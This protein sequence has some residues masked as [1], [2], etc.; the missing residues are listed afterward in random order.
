MNSIIEWRRIHFV[1]FESKMSVCITIHN[2]HQQFR[3]DVQMD[4]LAIALD[5]YKMII[6]MQL[7]IYLISK[8]YEIFELTF[9]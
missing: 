8:T 9:Q 6:S 4:E 7:N 1:C 5:K 2:N 3:G